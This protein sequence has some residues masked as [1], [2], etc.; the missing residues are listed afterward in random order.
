MNILSHI[1]SKAH[2][3]QRLSDAQMVHL[4]HTSYR[5]VPYSK[6]A[7]PAMVV[8]TIEGKRYECVEI[9]D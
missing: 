8:K 2:K 7:K 5:G 9:E 6:S 3:L 4:Q 1:Q